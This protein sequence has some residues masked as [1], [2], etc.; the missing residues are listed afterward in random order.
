MAKNILV[1][2]PQPAFGEL[3]RLSLEESGRYRVRL[4]QTG[5]EAL[6]S[7]EHIVFSLAILDASLAEP[8]FRYV[9]EGLRDRQGDIRL[10]VIPPLEGPAAPEISAARPDGCVSQPF[11]APYLLETIDHLTQ[12]AAPSQLPIGSVVGAPVHPSLQCLP[13]RTPA[14]RIP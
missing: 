10:L 14:E 1:A 5:G 9:A 3:L 12:S 11:Y 13:G 4:V 2:T 7:A 6:S 8:P